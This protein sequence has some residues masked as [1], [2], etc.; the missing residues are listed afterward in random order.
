MDRDVDARVVCQGGLDS[1]A[2][3][4]MLSSSNPGTATRLVNYEVG[5]GGGYR[6]LSG[7]VNFGDEVGVGVSEGPVLGIAIFPNASTGV[8]EYIAA[9]KLTSGD[10][11]KFYLKDGDDWD[12]ITTGLTHTYSGTIEKVRYAIG[13]DGVNNF[14]C[15]VDGVNNAVLYDGTTWAFIDSS[16]TGA[17]MA[18]AGGSQA[19]DAPQLVAF[20]AGQLILAADST[21]T[22]SGILAA[23]APNAFFDF[24][25]ANGGQQ[26]IAG[27]EIVEC[28]TIQ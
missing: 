19:L 2:N 7:Y 5:S 17:D 4:L 25:A 10:E 15:L 28:I 8:T 11:Y 3:H 24:T 22:Q 26:V 6:R 16:S 12:E 1:T 9:R 13:N 20:F 23:S 14:I 18:H 21:N 27:L